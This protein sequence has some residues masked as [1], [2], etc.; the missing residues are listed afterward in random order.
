MNENRTES[1]IRGGTQIPVADSPDDAVLDGT[2]TDP[3]DFLASAGRPVESGEKPSTDIPTIALASAGLAVFDAI[4]VVVLL[5]LWAVNP[6]VM[7]AIVKT[8]AG[9]L[10]L[11]AV[12]PIVIGGLIMHTNKQS[13]VVM[14]G[15]PWAGVGIL[16]GAILASLTLVIPLLFAVRLLLGGPVDPAA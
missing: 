16:V 10:L 12:A 7:L 5:S 15:T 14:A 11:L 13:G 1:A 6:E 4:I 2:F 3:A 9:I 8:M